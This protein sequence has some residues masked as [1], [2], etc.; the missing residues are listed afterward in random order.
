[1]GVCQTASLALVKLKSR[2]LIGGMIVKVGS[3]MIDSSV[4]TKLN[5]LQ[6]AM[7]GVG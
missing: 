5:K 7:K 2:A 1:M 6:I 3:R 4:R